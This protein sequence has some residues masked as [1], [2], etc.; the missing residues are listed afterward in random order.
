MRSEQNQCA[1]MDSERRRR[2][3]ENALVESLSKVRDL[4]TQNAAMKL[5]LVKV[6]LTNTLCL[7]RLRIF[8]QNKEPVF[9][10]EDE[11]AKMTKEI[12]EEQEN[13]Q[14]LR[15][16][17]A[18]AESAVRLLSKERSWSRFSIALTLIF[19]VAEAE[20]LLAEQRK[21]KDALLMKLCSQNEQL[22]SCEE[23]R[24][25]AQLNVQ[26]YEKVCFRCS[27]TSFFSFRSL[28]F[29]QFFV[30]LVS[31]NLLIK[32]VSVSRIFCFRKLTHY[33]RSFWT[34]PART[35]SSYQRKVKNCKK[36]LLGK[37][38]NTRMI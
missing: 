8:L 28:S 35:T 22:G 7:I 11:M 36:N 6:I 14:C 19:K 24:D 3:A 23:E 32:K 4:E 18:N 2:T 1:L 29:M 25:I 27:Q 15:Q 30:L 17:L 5:S 9:Q 10:A 21:E 13:V 20:E 31:L 33:E 38:S 12:D 34:L 16:K 37:L 26:K